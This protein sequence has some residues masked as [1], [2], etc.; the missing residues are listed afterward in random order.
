MVPKA[1]GYSFEVHQEG[2][3][4]QCGHA[5]NVPE[6]IH[7]VLFKLTSIFFGNLGDQVPFSRREVVTI[8]EKGWLPGL[9]SNEDMKPFPSE[10]FWFDV[11]YPLVIDIYR[12]SARFLEFPFSF[13]FFQIGKLTGIPLR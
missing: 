9:V 5:G 12:G 4:C 2:V 11:P 10:G 8:C 7:Y 6:G 13:G 3:A 1:V